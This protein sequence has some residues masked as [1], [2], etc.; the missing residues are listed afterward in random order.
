MTPYGV[1]KHAWMVPRKICYIRQTYFQLV[2]DPITNCSVHVPSNPPERLIVE[3]VDKKHANTIPGLL[4]GFFVVPITEFGGSTRQGIPEG[5]APLSSDISG[6]RR[7]VRFTGF[8]IRAAIYCTVQNSQ[9][10]S[11]SGVTIGH[12]K[13]HG[14]QIESLYVVVSKERSLESLFSRE[15]E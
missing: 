2:F 1:A 5:D 15:N 8:P 10:S 9:G 11:F 14:G 6:C 13:F 3:L 7:D 12:M 4:A